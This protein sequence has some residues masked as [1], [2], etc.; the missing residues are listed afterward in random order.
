MHENIFNL[1]ETVG[2]NPIKKNYRRTDR[3][4]FWNGDR[5]FISWPT[6]FFVFS[7]RIVTHLVK[8]NEKPEN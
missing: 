3:N 5:V 4:D 2:N 6:L 1:D 7:T 8:T